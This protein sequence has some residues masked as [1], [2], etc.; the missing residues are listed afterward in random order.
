MPAACPYHSSVAPGETVVIQSSIL[1]LR[2]R[3][4][5]SL[6]SSVTDTRGVNV[7]WAWAAAAATRTTTMLD[8]T[9]TNHFF[10]APP[11]RYV[12]VYGES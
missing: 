10:I 11:I 3:S 9:H 7:N 8:A 1:F 4:M 12:C 5:L 2:S 6:Y